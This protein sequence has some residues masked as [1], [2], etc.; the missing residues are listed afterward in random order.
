MTMSVL[1]IHLA[2]YLQQ[3]GIDPR[4]EKGKDGRVI[5]CYDPDER[6]F[7]IQD[8]FNKD[9]DLQLFISCLKKM[10][11]KM[12]DARDNK[13]NGYGDHNANGRYQKAL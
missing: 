8:D 1:D 9:A 2:A 11:G 13:T 5:F 10:R 12:L 3:N 4:F 7:S 6:F